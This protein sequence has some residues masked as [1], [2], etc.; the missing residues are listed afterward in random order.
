MTT[1]H[2][3]YLPPVKIG[4]FVAHAGTVGIDADGALIVEAGEDS[5]GNDFVSVIATADELTAKERKAIAKRMIAIWQSF[6]DTAPR[7]GA[8]GRVT[9]TGGA[10]E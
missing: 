4:R 5:T 9:Q 6:A 7:N 3:Q 8:D 10:N 2:L 1:R